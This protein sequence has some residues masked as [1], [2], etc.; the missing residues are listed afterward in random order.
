MKIFSFLLRR[1]P[2]QQITHIMKYPLV[3]MW[4]AD[5]S[6]YINDTDQWEKKIKIKTYISQRIPQGTDNTSSLLSCQN[7]Y[8]LQAILKD[9]I[10]IKTVPQTIFWLFLVLPK[11]NT[12]WYIKQNDLN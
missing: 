11:A 9:S 3:A 10:E 5:L 8:R 7:D 4:M 2:S 6:I 12:N 1:L